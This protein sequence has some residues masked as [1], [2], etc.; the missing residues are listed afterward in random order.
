MT[1]KLKRGCAKSHSCHCQGWRCSGRPGFQTVDGMHR[2]P[3]PFHQIGDGAI[4]HPLALHHVLA[5]EHGRRH[6]DVE[7][8]P[9]PFTPA[10]AS[11]IWRTMA[12]RS[13]S[14]TEPWTAICSWKGSFRDMVVPVWLVV[15]L[16]RLRGHCLGNLL[17]GTHEMVS[18]RYKTSQFSSSAKSLLCEF[19]DCANRHVY[20]LPSVEIRAR[21]QVEQKACVTLE[22]T[23]ISPLPSA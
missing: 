8:P 11:A 4:H 14:M 13:A 1:G 17:F 18:R 15:V 9:P 22:M 16:S 19:P 20:S 5:G 2:R 12:S 7:V 10:R 6:L 21:V 23:P 3:V